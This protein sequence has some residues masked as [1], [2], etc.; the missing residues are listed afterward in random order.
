MVN[1]TWTEGVQRAVNEAFEVA[2]SQPEVALQQMESLERTL[3]DALGE[4]EAP[5]EVT[6]Q[7]TMH[8]LRFV[9]YARIATI[10]FNQTGRP[11]DNIANN[12]E[13]ALRFY[14]LARGAG[15]EMGIWQIDGVINLLELCQPGGS[16]EIL[17]AIKIKHLITA[18]RIVFPPIF[19][20]AVEHGAISRP[21]VDAIAEVELT[22]PKGTIRY[23]I[24]GWS[25]P[26]EWLV[27]LYE[28][29][30]PLGSSHPG[31][32]HVGKLVK[33]AEQWRFGV[34]GNSSAS[35]SKHKQTASAK[36]CIGSLLALVSC[37]ASLE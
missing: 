12:C 3:R 24:V 11:S 32:I 21:E 8:A 37:R 5:A 36:G 25:G 20:Q 1:D 15:S 23:A 17:K 22:A 7:S 14:D 4:A 30:A 9:A 29:V 16:Y 28:N 13:L 33:I 6:L 31:V 2:A 18:K 27:L 35:E 10:E 34:A 26:D 19:L